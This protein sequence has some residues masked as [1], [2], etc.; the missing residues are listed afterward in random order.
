[1]LAC[2]NRADKTLAALAALLSQK[3]CGDVDLRVHL[4]DDDSTD[5]TPERVA[6]LFSDRRSAVDVAGPGPA[7]SRE[8]TVH[9]GN[10]Q[11]FWNGGM[12]RAFAAALREDHDHYLWLNDDTIMDA[13]ALRTLLDTHH[14]VSDEVGRPIIVAGSTR[15]P[16][17]G[18]LTYGGVNR[19]SRMRPLR[20]DLITPGTHPRASETMNGNCVLIPRA[21]AQRV[22]NLEPGYRHGMG[23][24]DYGLRARAAGCEVWI[25]AGT[26]ATCSTNPVA[27]AGQGPLRDEWGRVRS[28][29]GLPPADWKVFARRWAG[30][31]WP[32]YW[33]SPYVR[34]GVAL[35]RQR[36]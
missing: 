27:R 33:A 26:I 2:H 17:T 29:K 6:A 15:D 25:T 3:G 13:D 10:G 9:H 22:G 7:T 32:V 16:D 34:R 35:L 28:T 1:V 36:L 5:G 30:A 12:R 24:Y 18:A 4:L 19:P 8:V 31:L 20:F 14:A 11:L 23:D 21:V